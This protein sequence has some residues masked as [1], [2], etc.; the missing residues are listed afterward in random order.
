MFHKPSFPMSFALL[1]LVAAVVLARAWAAPEAPH[2]APSQEQITHLLKEVRQLADQ[3]DEIGELHD[4]AQRRPL[5]ARHWQ[6]VQTYLREVQAYLPTAPDGHIQPLSFGSAAVCSLPA[7]IDADAY[8]SRMRDVLWAMRER[9]ADAYASQ[10]PVERLH[11]LQEHARGAYRGVQ[12]VRGFGWNQGSATPV[13]RASQVV[14]DSASEPAY[15][16]RRYCSQ[17]HAPPPP[18]LHSANEWSTVASK[19]TEHMR[20]AD[21]SSP[22]EV[23]Q[24]TAQELAVIVS[25]LEANGCGIGP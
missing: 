19:M 8:Q 1:L 5:I 13:A 7:T 24:P 23:E 2:R 6:A 11:L 14:P 22:G 3:L 25:Y 4:A 10:D 16:V 9:L 20:V 15:L 18:E 12:L 21:A 17:C